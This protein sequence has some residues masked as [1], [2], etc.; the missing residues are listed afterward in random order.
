MV[1]LVFGGKTY[2]YEVV[3]EVPK[4]GSIQFVLGKSK[5]DCKI[6]LF[7]QGTSLVFIPCD[8]IGGTITGMLYSYMY[9]NH[10]NTWAFF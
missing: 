5:P 7:I 8:F 10:C 1:N 3:G 9:F 6:R 2:D 4:K